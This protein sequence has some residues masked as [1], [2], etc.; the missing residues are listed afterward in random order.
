M[1]G[2]RAAAAAAAAV[3]V[4][5]VAARLQGGGAGA[6]A[7]RLEV[8]RQ[9]RDA[10]SEYLHRLVTEF[11]RGRLSLAEAVDLLLDA[12]R[13]YPDWLETLDRQYPDAPDRRARVAR[14]LVAGVRAESDRG[15]GAAG[16]V[17]AEYA[18]MTAGPH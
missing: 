10:R 12:G 2:V 4:G 8:M 11:V 6:E 17:A 1:R 3:A 13:S 7:A 16:R 9:E 5:L 18:G 14:T 15:S